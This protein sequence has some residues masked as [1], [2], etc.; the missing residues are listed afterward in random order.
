LVQRI[1]D[2]RSQDKADPDYYARHTVVKAQGA[3]RTALQNDV[4]STI[5]MSPHIEEEIQ[6]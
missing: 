5:P 4:T 1:A 3:L 6:H 2:Y